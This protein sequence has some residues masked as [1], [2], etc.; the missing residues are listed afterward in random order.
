[1]GIGYYVNNCNILACRVNMCE[2][3]DLKPNE[4]RKLNKLTKERVRGTKYAF[5]TMMSQYI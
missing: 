1:M 3:M 5:F 4:K 2:Y